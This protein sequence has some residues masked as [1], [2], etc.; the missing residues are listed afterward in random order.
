ME[1]IFDI[2]IVPMTSA[3][4]VLTHEEEM[5]TRYLEAILSGVTD[6]AQLILDQISSAP[7]C[8]ASTC[9]LMGLCFIHPSLKSRIQQKIGDA[10]PETRLEILDKLKLS[11]DVVANYIASTVLN[12]LEKQV[13]IC[14]HLHQSS[15]DEELFFG[16]WPQDGESNNI[17]PNTC[18]KTFTNAARHQE[19]EHQ[20]FTAIQSAICQ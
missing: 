17:H 6:F 1:T 18:K 5:A 10:D 3:V 13:L 16:A 14:E 2:A 4:V 8:M 20:I 7:T 11:Q 12:R 9:L 15:I 19:R